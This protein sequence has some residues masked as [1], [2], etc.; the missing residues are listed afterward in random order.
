MKV[1][2]VLAVHKAVNVQLFLDVKCL[3]NFVVPSNM[4]VEAIVVL[5]YKSKS[6]WL[7]HVWS[8]AMYL[9]EA[10][11]HSLH[12]LFE[13]NVCCSFPVPYLPF[14]NLTLCLHI[15]NYLLQVVFL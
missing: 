11:S 3:C 6:S 12:Y 10:F 15:L 7:L 13:F 4:I 8:N 1:D 2:P 9:K 5:T 14:L